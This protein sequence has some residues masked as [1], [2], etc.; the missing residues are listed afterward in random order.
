MGH[1]IHATLPGERRNQGNA[2]EQNS[3][4][5]HTDTGKKYIKVAGHF[6]SGIAQCAGEALIHII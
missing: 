5:M 3:F 4:E 6:A 2:R 1:E